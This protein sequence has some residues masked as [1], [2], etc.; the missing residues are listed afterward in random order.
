VPSRTIVER[1]ERVATQSLLEKSKK[2][3]TRGR[4]GWRKRMCPMCGDVWMEG[5][6]VRVR[7]E[8]FYVLDATGDHDRWMWIQ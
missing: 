4:R 5:R 2:G 3:N 6:Q 1:E 7:M 8:V